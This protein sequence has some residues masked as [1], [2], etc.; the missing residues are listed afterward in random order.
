[1]VKTKHQSFLRPSH[2]AWGL[3]VLLLLGA[4]ILLWPVLLPSSES[5]LLFRLLFFGL[6]ILY[7]FALF[8]ILRHFWFGVTSKNKI[9]FYSPEFGW[10]KN[11]GDSVC[12]SKVTAADRLL[13]RKKWALEPKDIKRVYVG[14]LAYAVESLNKTKRSE[15][16]NFFHKL[17]RKR[18]EKSKR[19]F[20]N[21][22]ES[23]GYRS[24]G[25]AAAFIPQFVIGLERIII[26][27][28]EAED[29][30]SKA[31]FKSAGMYSRD[32]LMELCDYL[33]NEGVLEIIIDPSLKKR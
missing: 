32:S 27:E 12:I 21:A 20:S 15:E 13:K 14:S 1:M 31:V 18:F 9:I 5:D 6:G 10:Q 3:F 22:K 4:S 25:Y 2:G 23:S 11:P 17:I 7:I 19:E 30:L 33:K 29:M 26:F 24:G 28:I 8:I 16:Q